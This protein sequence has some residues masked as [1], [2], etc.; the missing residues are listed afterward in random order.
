M[1]LGLAN[2]HRGELFRYSLDKLVVL[3]IAGGREDHVATEE[4]L[5]VVA[6]ELVLIEFAHS[7]CG[8]QNRL[9]QRMVLPE[10]LRE[11]LVN[12]DVRIVFVDLDFLEDHAAFALNVTQ[13]RSPD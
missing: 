4:A 11:E 12:E 6:E 2:A 9:P 1:P 8:A 3:K 13:E 5:L 10:V 7:G